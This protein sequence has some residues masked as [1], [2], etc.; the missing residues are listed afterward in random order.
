MTNPYYN[1]LLP[2][3]S[4]EPRNAL[5]DAAYPRK[6]LWDWRL[7][8]EW[9]AGHF[10]LVHCGLLGSRYEWVPGYWRRSAL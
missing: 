2:P 1:A 3:I 6:A 10:K 5:L 9:V 4:L 8:D 7:K